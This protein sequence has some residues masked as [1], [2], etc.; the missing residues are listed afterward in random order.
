MPGSLPAVLTP[1]WMAFSATDDR[2]SP[3]PS[4]TP[5]S[6]TASR[7]SLSYPTEKNG[8]LLLLDSVIARH[9]VGKIMDF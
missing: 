1:F 3:A 2:A 8:I 6:S 7:R 9:T 5:N 4:S